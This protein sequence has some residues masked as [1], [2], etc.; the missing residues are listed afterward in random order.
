MGAEVAFAN[1]PNRTIVA[2][3]HQED[4]K[5]GNVV[6]TCSGPQE[7]NPEILEKSTPPGDHIPLRNDIP[8]GRPRSSDRPGRSGFPP[9]APKEKGGDSVQPPDR[10]D[11]MEPV[12]RGCDLTL[13]II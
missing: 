3:I 2:D 6:Q 7:K 12:P 9:R 4:R 11:S 13:A 10:M 1:P 8:P 5:S